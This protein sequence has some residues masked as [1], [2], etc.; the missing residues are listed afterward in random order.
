MREP[1]VHAESDAAW[2]V[3]AV[4]RERF[5][6]E[7]FRPGQREAI[8]ELLTGG[9]LLCIQP[10]GH[11]KSLLYQLPA[12]LLD[13]LTLVV[14]P[15]LA[16]MRDQIDHLNNRF[17]IPA[18]SINSDQT[19]EENAAARAAARDGAL[20]ILFVAPEQL[21]NVDR[22]QLLVDLRV[23]LLVIDE[24][25]CIS[26][27]GHDFRPSYREI[28]RLVA[29]L[30]VRRPDARVLGLTATADRRAEA[31][32]AR[33][34]VPG[35]RPLPV[36]RRTMDRP[37]LALEVVPCETYATKLAW[38]SDAVA[39]LPRPGLIYCA[40]RQNTEIVATWLAQ[41]A[42]QA[43]YEVAAYH[44]GMDPD[45]KRRLQ[46]DF[47]AGRFAAIAA[48]N[49]L[50]MGI[51]KSDLRYVIHFDVPGTTTA[52]YQEV[53]RAGRDGQPARG[54]LL[55]CP[56]DRRIQEHFIRSAR[57]APGDFDAIL[58]VI[59]RRPEPPRLT[60][61]K[62]ACGL[63][64]TRVTVVVAELVEQGFVVKESRGGVQVYV[65]TG[66]TEAPVL[67]RYANQEQVRRAGLDRMTAYGEGRVGCLMRALCASLGD[68]ETG[69][70]GRCGPC[71]GRAPEL[72][73]P[74]AVAAADLWLEHRPVI[75]PG[76]RK[77]LSAGVALYDSELRARHFVG[78]MRGRRAAES[79]L[80]PALLARL[81]AIAQPLHAAHGFTAVV[82]L[83]SNT[84]G[85]R[86]EALA[87]VSRA[88]GVPG[89]GELLGWAQEPPSRQGELLNNDQR[90][91]NVAGKMRAAPGAGLAGP[92]LLLDDY[93]GSGA[94]L[95]EAARVL[96]KELK[97]A[98]DIV[99]LTIARVRWRLGKPGMV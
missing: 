81:T 24:A 29:A 72:P 20:K 4:L 16:L 28:A 56:A 42:S 58:E 38:L 86:S 32:I 96:R 87:H 12:V 13:G 40:T 1:H 19:D 91:A 8:V 63:H 35:D 52:S 25:H 90:R 46:A 2:P 11:G 85:Q 26:T 45:A 47:L 73:T 97:V 49:A 76:F 69:D 92:V 79:G 6:F 65:A 15:L 54:V 62:I 70:C 50:G 43:G 99:P 83:P 61:I 84:W 18:A 30:R 98:G 71:L 3:D 33:Q 27:W 68:S 17:G 94:T 77:V 82:A 66:R 80:A 9:S 41:S 64:P 7:A 60:D 48:T 22:F 53:G 89:L 23:S 37:N 31:D 88:I 59:R 39:R 21:D 36:H 75:V 51:D 34:L 95:R 93:M 5:G 67:E 74:A 14:S 55:Y 57:P 10:T 44:A 78:F